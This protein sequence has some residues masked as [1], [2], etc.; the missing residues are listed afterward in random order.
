MRPFVESPF[1]IANPLLA[2]AMS[3]LR[4]AVTFPGGIALLSGGP[5]VGK[6]A[7][8]AHSLAPAESDVQVLPIDLRSAEPADFHDALLDG[9]GATCLGPVDGQPPGRLRAAL[10][11]QRTSGRQLILSLDIP[12]INVDL[13]RRLLRFL[14]LGARLSPTGHPR[15]ARP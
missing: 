6:S 9:L 2:N 14:H 4:H 10:L 1:F 12:G 3:R 7:F 15:T 5:G 8:V 13:A 11:A